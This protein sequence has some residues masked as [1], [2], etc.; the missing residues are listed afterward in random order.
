VPLLVARPEAQF[1]VQFWFL[2]DRLVPLVLDN[3]LC[4]TRLVS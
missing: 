1:V 3:A 2:F 4:G